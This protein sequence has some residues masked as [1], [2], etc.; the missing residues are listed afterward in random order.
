MLGELIE[1]G[2][3][4]HEVSN[5]FQQAGE[6]R[7]KRIAEYFLQIE[8]CLRINI[9]GL[10]RLVIR[11]AA[12]KFI[13]LVIVQAF[14]PFAALARSLSYSINPDFSQRFKRLAKTLMPLRLEIKYPVHILL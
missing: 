9:A 12:L 8:E 4:L 11:N 7:R 5:N 14:L 1:V 13:T 6:A 2:N 10:Y 3:K